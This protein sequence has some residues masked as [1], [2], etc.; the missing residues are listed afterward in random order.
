MSSRN[1]VSFL[2]LSLYDGSPEIKTTAEGNAKSFTLFSF[3]FSDKGRKLANRNNMENEQPA[4]TDEFH[5]G[6]MIKAELARQGRSITWLAAQINC[7]RENLYQI[8]RNPWIHAETLY[9][10]GQALDCDFFKVC[11]DYHNAQK[12]KKN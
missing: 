8:F 3:A 4:T 10:I 7:S 1:C 2:R 6:K 11:S 9:K 5:L 12:E